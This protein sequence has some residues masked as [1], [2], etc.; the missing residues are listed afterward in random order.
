MIQGLGRHLKDRKVLQWLLAYLAGAW[1]VLQVTDILGDQFSWPLGLQRAI[2][3][4]LGVGAVLTAVLA[5]YH[6]E[7]GRQRVTGTELIM[8][9]VVLALGGGALALL[10]PE[11]DIESLPELASADLPSLA[12]LP[13]VHRS[14]D[15]GDEFFTAG[16]HDEIL[17]RVFNVNGIRVISRTSVEAY[18]DT[19][20]T[21]PEIAREL[22]VQYIAEGAVQRAG[23]RVRI[24]AQLLD[25]QRD[26]HL[27][28]DSFDRET[29]MENLLAVQTEIAAAIA[30]AVGARLTPREVELVSAEPTDD[31]QAYEYFLQARA[32]PTR[33]SADAA[34]E[35]EGL[36]ERSVESD[37][38]F[39]DAWVSLA[40]LRAWMT[41]GWFDV[42]FDEKSEPAGEALE[43]VEALRP[44]ADQTHVARAIYTFYA[45]PGGTY[46]EAL[47]HFEAADRI[48]DE[49]DLY[50]YADLLRRTGRWDESL[51][52]MR[53]MVSTNPRSREAIGLLGSTLVRL[54][55]YEEGRLLLERA[56]DLDPGPGLGIHTARFHAAFSVLGDT[57]DLQRLIEES[58]IQTTGRWA[59][60]LRRD[61]TP[62][63]SVP[64]GSVFTIFNGWRRTPQLWL[65]PSVR[66]FYGDSL[67]AMAAD[68]FLIPSPIPR[69]RA[70]AALSLAAALDG[71]RDEAIRQ[72][73]LSLEAL[74][75][76]EGA[77]EATE[78]HHVVS[79]AYVIVGEAERAIDLL[80]ELLAVP[81]TV[82]ETWLRFDPFY[83]ALRGN[84]RFQRLVS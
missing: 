24:T 2:T 8:L 71:Q 22:G 47:L 76:S 78:F 80:E 25:G 69:G 59:S 57:T 23:G 11:G 64:R 48:V 72:G 20:M 38:D 70:Y 42:F 12:V 43:R 81:S 50:V 4:T 33:R 10:A 41:W 28:A 45:D 51:Q 30:G 36:L 31:L 55:R 65:D 5:W 53:R 61:Y 9:A 27:W 46:D 1:L 39:V 56:I 58:L 3:I 16:I 74:P 77:I 68:D 35:A 18:R 29:S 62:S 79:I 52:V 84:A 32:L 21:V 60:Y 6:G 54:R 26:E 63:L 75:I 19:D 44:D 66:P 83:D 37:P 14:G 82:Y 73:Q 15:E 40:R 34:R 49:E 7:E 13:F 17:T 67:R